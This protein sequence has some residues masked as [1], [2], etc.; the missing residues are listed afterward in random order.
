MVHPL[1]KRERSTHRDE[2]PGEQGMR[3]SVA[4]DRENQPSQ[5]A[6]ERV[7]RYL[8]QSALIQAFA[9]SYGEGG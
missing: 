2:H 5:V 6:R 1:N 7:I 8:A 4:L 3:V 9:D